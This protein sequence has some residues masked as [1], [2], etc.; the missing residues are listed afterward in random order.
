VDLPFVSLQYKL[1]KSSV[2]SLLDGGVVTLVY[3]L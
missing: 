1:D 3:G 2:Y